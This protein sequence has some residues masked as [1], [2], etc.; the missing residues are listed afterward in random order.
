VNVTTFAPR[1]CKRNDNIQL[2]VAL[3]FATDI[4][5]RGLGLLRAVMKFPF[6]VS[7]WE[8][9]EASE[10][11]SAQKVQAMVRGNQDRKKL[12]AE[13]GIVTK[14][15]AG[16]KYKAEMYRPATPLER[17]VQV[18]MQ[19]LW[20]KKANGKAELRTFHSIRSRATTVHQI[21]GQLKQAFKDYD[22]DGNG[23][24]ELDEAQA[25]LKDMGAVVTDREME[26][27]FMEAFAPPASKFE[28]FKIALK[29]QH[30]KRQTAHLM[31]WEEEEYIETAK[32]LKG[33]SGEPW[34][35][36]SDTQPSIDSGTTDKMVNRKLPNL[37]KKLP[38]PDEVQTW[39]RESQQAFW[40]QRRKYWNRWNYEE[41]Q[42]SCLDRGLYP[43]GAQRFV[44]DRLLRYD[45]ARGT[46]T[47]DELA[48][49]EPPAEEDEEKEEEEEE[50][51]GNSSLA[52]SDS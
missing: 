25:A 4:I 28:P 14:A 22:L 5:F 46:L 24:I 19:D 41:L 44:K 38:E 16:Q 7:W 51:D 43:V 1:E 30:R 9:K 49:Y 15:L 27:L 32:D 18:I 6:V 2:F 26:F 52:S 40:E 50:E 37:S 17:K 3:S 35:P 39:T 34:P 8:T 23:T 45:Y 21:F 31:P 20:G 36:P 47:T 12:R 29:D 11:A 10:F 48:T 13:K 42:Q 33:P